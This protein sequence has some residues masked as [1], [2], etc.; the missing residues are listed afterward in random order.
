MIY[1]HIARYIDGN[2]SKP[3]ITEMHNVQE[4]QKKTVSNKLTTEC[5]ILLFL[6]FW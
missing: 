4:T 5:F 2:A 3:R 6:S 1:S